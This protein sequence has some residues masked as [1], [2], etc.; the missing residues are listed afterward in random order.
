MCAIA[1]LRFDPTGGMTVMDISEDD[2]CAVDIVADPKAPGGW[3]GDC[4]EIDCDGECAHE[5]VDTTNP[6]TGV[7]EESVISCCC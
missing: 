3:R 5:R 1:H 6:Q 2:N 7:L 4:S